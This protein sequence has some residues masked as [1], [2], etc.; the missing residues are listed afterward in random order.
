M[1]KTVKYLIKN[2]SQLKSIT[3]K[4]ASELEDGCL[5]LLEGDLGAGKTTFVR[6]LGEGLKAKQP[7]TSPTFTLIQN[8]DAKIP[9]VHIDL[10]RIEKEIDIYFLDITEILDKEDHLVCIEWAER[11]GKYIP[12]DYMLITLSYPKIIENNES[13][14]ELEV[15][16]IGT[17]YQSVF[18]KIK[19]KLKVK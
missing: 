3:K 17:K 14:R 13:E 11:L 6:Y 7:I 9:I 19:T 4:I 12:K 2:E 1:V 15:G 16:V 8:Y 10:Y 5:L 18:Q